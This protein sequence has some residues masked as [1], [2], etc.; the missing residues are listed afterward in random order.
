[1]PLDWMDVETLGAAPEEGSAH[2]PLDPRPILE[3][4]NPA[5]REAVEHGAGPLLILAGAGSGKTRV[6]TRRIAWL[7]AT[8]Q[9]RP[10][11]IL[12]I[13]FTNK[14][15]AEMRARCAAFFPVKG[16]WISTFHAMGA[17]ILRREIEAL[18]GWTRDFSI[19]DTYERNA[20]L[21]EIVKDLGYD[22]QRFRPAAIGAW[23]SDEKNQRF[24]EEAHLHGP[25]GEEGEVLE[26]VRVRYGEA[27]R[28]SNALDFD[29]LLLKVLEL[30]EAHPGVRDA[31][32]RR[33]RFVLVDE[34]QD[35]NRVQYRLT[36]HLAGHHGNLTVCGDP[37][38]SIY[39]WRGAD[40]GNILD[41]EHDFGGERPVVVVRLEQNY[42]STECILRAA[43]GLIRH[44]VARKEKDLWTERSSE[45]RVRVLECGDENDEALAI[46]GAIG[47]QLAAGRRADQVAIFYR[48]NFMQRALELALRRAGLPYQIV[49]GVEFYQR[50]EVRD[51][52]SYLRLLVNPRDDAAAARVLNVPGRGIGAKSAEEL[53]R[54]ARE[55]GRPL[56]AAAASR[57]ARERIKGR[58]RAGLEDFAALLERLALLASGPAELALEGVLAETDYLR[59]LSES[60]EPDV[61]SRLENVEEL[62]AGARQFDQDQPGGGLRGYLEEVALVS[63]VD[64]FEEASAR[65]TL[66]TLH[67]SKG[68]EFPCVH[69]AGLEEGLLP[70]ARALEDDPHHGLEEERRLL[71]VGMT[72]AMDELSLTH[73]RVRLHFGTTSLQSPSRF[74]AEIPAEWTEREDETPEAHEDGPR[75]VADEESEPEELAPGARVEHDHFG[76]GVVEGVQGRGGGARLTVRFAG[77]GTR[78]LLAQYAR[79]RRVR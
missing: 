60:G 79:L 26:K 17:R 2:P 46:A 15:A 54:W 43:Q 42:R 47:R 64:A 5:Q 12:A 78:V 73:A 16:L 33:F 52:I 69:V 25:G 70:H 10:G 74:L 53:G 3:G 62:L 44:N 56:A 24:G 75:Y 67:A 20:L 27:L 77:A 23:I 41:F 21:K 61:R 31:Y 49:G 71:Y 58:A 19:F 14:A 68:L 45:A 50:K 63:D 22:P 4:L 18:G 32:A 8:A 36:R 55:H 76:Y 66:M 39:A 28:T 72:R 38:Q 57:E 30:F 13:T 48:A 65:V 37:D 34:Y 11:E 1:M 29:D 6:I 35:T 51:L 40:L 9:A 7:V 59:H